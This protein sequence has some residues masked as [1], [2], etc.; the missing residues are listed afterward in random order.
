MIW[1]KIYIIVITIIVDTYKSGSK[2]RLHQRTMVL[3]SCIEQNRCYQS[4]YHYFEYKPMGA[5][6]SPWAYIRGGLY[7][8]G[9]FCQ[10]IIGLIFEGAYNRGGLYSRFY[11][12]LAF[13][14]FILIFFLFLKTA[15]LGVF[16]GCVY[17]F[18]FDRKL[19]KVYM[20]RLDFL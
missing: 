3:S 15:T 1:F 6:G 7:S 13:L 19:F 11:G 14:L 10:Q 12:I 9:F 17:G 8:N 20:D 2:F 18:G 4:I 5:H 16:Y